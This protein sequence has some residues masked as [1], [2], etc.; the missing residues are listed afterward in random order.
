MFSRKLQNSFEEI[1]NVFNSECYCLGCSSSLISPSPQF[2]TQIYIVVFLRLG[3]TLQQ[4]LL[5]D[6]KHNGIILNKLAKTVHRLKPPGSFSII[7]VEENQ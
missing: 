5:G 1:H 7:Y 3:N 6:C 2:P 4:S